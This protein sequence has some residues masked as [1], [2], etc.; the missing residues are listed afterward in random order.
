MGKR[1]LG[2]MKPVLRLL[3]TS[4]QPCRGRYKCCLAGGGSLEDFPVQGGFHAMQL[5]RGGRQGYLASPF[6]SMGFIPEIR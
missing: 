3:R 1:L 4:N 2:C 5:D 6:D